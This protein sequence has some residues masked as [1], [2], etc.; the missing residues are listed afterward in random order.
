MSIFSLVFLILTFQHLTFS[1][2]LEQNKPKNGGVAFFGNKFAQTP[3]PKWLKDF[4]GMDQWPGLDPPY[5]PLDFIDMNRIKPMI[6]Y[7]QGECFKVPRDIC[8]F[9]CHGC[10]QFDDINSCPRLSQTFD[11]GPSLA[12]GKLL[13]NLNHKS[14]FFVLGIN[15]V[16]YPDIYRR[17]LAEGHLVGSHT[18]SHKYLPS[19]S[20]EEIIAQIEWSIWAMNATGHHYPKWFRPPYGATDDRV[21][22][23]TRQFGFQN[24]L[25][26]HDTFDWSLMTPRPQKDERTIYSDARRWKNQGTGLIL[27]HDGSDR[28][29]NVGIRLSKIIG[30]NQLTVAQCVNGHNYIREYSAFTNMEDEQIDFNDYDLENDYEEEKTKQSEDENKNEGLNDLEENDDT[31]NNNSASGLKNSEIKYSNETKKGEKFENYTNFENSEFIQLVNVDKIGN[32]N[33]DLTD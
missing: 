29:V 14:T 6:T 23:I 1:E 5:I 4:T 7:S 26:N 13:N 21:R 15:V 3:F 10:I 33:Y 32:N 18:W 25:W 24:V 16:N 9:D 31:G 11:D 17:I 20:N 22:S 27:E 12:T 2:E 19:L 28:T 8:S 30:P